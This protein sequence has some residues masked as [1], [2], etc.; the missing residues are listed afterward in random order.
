MKKL[1]ILSALGIILFSCSIQK[2]TEKKLPNI[3]ILYADDMGYG[4]LGV[5]NPDSK[6]PTPNL[7]QLA[8]EGMRFTDGHSSSG[9]CTPSRYALL[10]GQY[11][12]RK[13]HDI[14][15]SFGPPVFDEKQLTLPEMLKE[16]GYGTACIG[17]WHLGWN[18]NFLG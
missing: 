6:I 10:T 4:D 13:F 7:D 3:V 17:K 1:L 2:A 15:N 12:W 8:S 9:I 14:V 11:H 18:W 5:Q 16:K